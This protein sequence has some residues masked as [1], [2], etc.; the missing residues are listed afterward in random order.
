MREVIARVTDDFFAGDLMAENRRMHGLMIG[1]VPITYFSHGEERHERARLIDWSNQDNAWH[2]FN[3]VDMVGRT[4]RIPDVI[5]Y[6][7]GLP[8]VVIELKGTEGADIEAAFN[9]LET[10]KSD[11]PNL[12]RTSMFSVISDGLN[13]R[14]GTL[15]AGLDRFMAWRT[16]D[17][18]TVVSEREGLALSTLTDGLLNPSVLLDMLGV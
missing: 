15:S 8:L 14:Y 11:I 18:D 5:I 3:Q 13:A 10:Y 4:P 2:A 7:N 17:G 16:V 12:F 6:L 1:G 9:Q